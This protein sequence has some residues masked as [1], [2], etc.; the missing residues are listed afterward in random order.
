VFVEGLLA[1]G[2][3]SFVPTVL[4]D[5]FGLALT[6]AG[7]ILALFALGG[8]VFS[9]AAPYLLRRFGPAAQ[10]RAAIVPLALGFAMLAAMP[11][12]AWAVVA[13][14]FAGFGFY[15]FH[16]TLQLSGTQLSTSSRGLAMSMFASGLFMGQ[17]AGVAIAAA[18]FARLHPAWGFGFAAVALALLGL[19]F[20]RHLDQR[21]SGSHDHGTT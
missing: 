16:N 5:R 13:C 4:H 1:F 15:A 21:M 14:P 18:M 20:A 19:F 9:R 3:L 2:F 7:A 17:A 12:W 6:E 8:L 11:H 10:A